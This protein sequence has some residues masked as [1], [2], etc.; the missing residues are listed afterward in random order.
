MIFSETG[1]ARSMRA[2][3]I[4]GLAFCWVFASTTA[5][6]T[7]YKWKDENGKPHFTNDPT[8]VPKTKNIDVETSK[9]FIAP[10]PLPLLKSRAFPKQMRALHKSRLPLRGTKFKEKYHVFVTLFLRMTK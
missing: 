1:V 5:H 9:E 10:P 8:K 6:A 7:I 4:V 3:L 2:F